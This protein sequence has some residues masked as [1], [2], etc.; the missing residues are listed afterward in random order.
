MY[1]LTAFCAALHLA[2][3]SHQLSQLQ[4]HEKKKTKQICEIARLIFVLLFVI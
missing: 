1:I 4:I 3:Y 2:S